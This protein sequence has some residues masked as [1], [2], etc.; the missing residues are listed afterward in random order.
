M[1][2]KITLTR[3]F[4]RMTAG[5]VLLWGL[6][7]CRDDASDP[8][9]QDYVEGEFLYL[10][11][12]EAG[13]I[14]ALPVSRGD[15]VAA[16]QLV[17][18]LENAVQINLLAE[19]QGRLNVVRH[20]LANLMSGKREQEIAVLIA[21]QRGAQANLA[22]SREKLDRKTGLAKD[23]IVSQADLDQARAEFDRDTATLDELNAE[24]TS[25]RLTARVD[26]IG[27]AEA[28][29]KSA[30]ASIE[31]ARWHLDKRQ[32]STPTTG[33]VEEILFDVGE[34]VQ[35][36]QPVVSILPD[37]GVKV[38]F[39]IP[40]S[41]LGEIHKGQEVTFDCDGCPQGMTGTIRY[42]STQAEYTPPVI[43]S[44]PS[45]QKLVFMA[46]AWP[47]REAPLHPGQPVAVR[48]TDEKE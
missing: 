31:T 17:F 27:A 5:A 40:E 42:I 32:V 3:A 13:H 48:L 45:Q 7:G 10:S 29:V 19:S 35:A 12:F 36:G 2:G 25:A 44:Q 6:G 15:R 18:G 14:E 28:A 1:H 23:G 11:A 43:F 8:G 22:L 33:R 38:R 34:F 30:E 39:F 16:G 24:I 9:F 47:T 41:R 46:E 4:I 21:G 37:D 26:E 20:Q